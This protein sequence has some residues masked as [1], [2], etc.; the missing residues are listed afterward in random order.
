MLRS[1]IMCMAALWLSTAA[2]AA[3][4]RHDYPLN[5]TP[6]DRLGGAP[7]RVPEGAQLGPKGYRFPENRGPA[8]TPSFDTASYTIELRFLIDRT[9]SWVKILDFSGLRLDE[10]FYS[11]FGRAQFYR[12]LGESRE[13]VIVPGVWVHAVLTRDG[14]SR[15]VTAWI[16]GREQFRF[17]DTRD[18]ARLTGGNRTLHIFVDEDVTARGE[19]SPGF[20]DYV[21]LWD[22]ALDPAG[23][24]RLHD[25]P[26]STPPCPGG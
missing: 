6:A 5:G 10:G 19:A 21:R 11:Y 17:T 14:P 15:T 3:G 12:G 26:G 23:V 22:C 18:L 8:I 1:L 13:T 2:E 4:L 20:L 7:A 24:A 9:E 25:E 16:D